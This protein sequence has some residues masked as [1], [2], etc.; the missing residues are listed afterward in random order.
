MSKKN[1][2]EESITN[3]ANENEVIKVEPIM[4][5]STHEERLI[6]INTIPYRCLIEGE[7][8]EGFAENE[9]SFSLLSDY[10][11]T[12]GGEIER[13]KS[14]KIVVEKMVYR[15]PFAKVSYGCATC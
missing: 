14:N 15:M 3:I 11:K 9:K 10:V 4:E 13:L 8:H 1:K 6:P 2:V 7:S 5:N 12:K